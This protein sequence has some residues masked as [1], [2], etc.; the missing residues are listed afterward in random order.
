M[1]SS[2]ARQA[3][4]EN[5]F[6][7]GNEA[8]RANAGPD[9]D[10]IVLICECGDPECLE[11]IGVR[12]DE[13]EGV[14]ANPRAFVLARGH[15][16]RSGDEAVVVDETDRFVVVEKLDDGTMV[17]RPHPGGPERRGP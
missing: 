16:E 1:D 11:R 9:V 8:I 3:H 7:A 14:R 4:N 13:Y 5:I 17:G 10:G 12:R 2:E 6:R 15:E